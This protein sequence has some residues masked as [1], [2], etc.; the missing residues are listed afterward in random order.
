[1]CAWQADGTCE[2]LMSANHLQSEG[3]VYTE[4][5]KLCVQDPD[6]ASGLPAGWRKCPKMS[7]PIWELKVIATKVRQSA[8]GS[9]AD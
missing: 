6:E 1:M 4:P 7:S 9:L 5:R 3:T 2:Q 8:A